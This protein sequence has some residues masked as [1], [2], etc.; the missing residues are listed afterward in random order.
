MS[1]EEENDQTQTLSEEGNALSKN[2]KR[3]W[4]KEKKKNLHLLR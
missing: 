2:N 3:E 4:K 1:A